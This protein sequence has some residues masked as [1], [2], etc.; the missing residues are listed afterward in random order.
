MV[1]S[2][3]YTGG[4]QVV[5][6]YYCNSLPIQYHNLFED[7]ALW[8]LKHDGTSC[9]DGVVVVDSIAATEAAMD[10]CRL[11]KK[12]QSGDR[13]TRG[14]PFRTAEVPTTP[15]VLYFHHCLLLVCRSHR[16]SVLLDQCTNRAG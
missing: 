12:K 14:L 10:I 7:G 15:S 8:V 16:H 6:P 4:M 5:V 2:A 13:L 3:E 1:P 11:S 9:G